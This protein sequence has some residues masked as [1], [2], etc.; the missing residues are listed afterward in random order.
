MKITLS[1][2]AVLLMVNLSFAQDTTK[3]EKERARKT[4]VAPTPEERAAMQTKRMTDQ[5][6]LTTDQQKQVEELTLR[7]ANANKKLA[8]T[9]KADREEYNNELKKILTPDQAKKWEE[10][11]SKTHARAQ[12]MNRQS[13]FKKRGS[14]VKKSEKWKERKAETLNSDVVAPVKE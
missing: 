7:Q 12:K 1:L 9:A 8:E 3:V 5:L 6:S 11:R 13:H 4:Y 14:M 2:A 10:N